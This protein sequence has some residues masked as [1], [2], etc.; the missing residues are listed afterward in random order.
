MAISSTSAL[1][2]YLGQALHPAKAEGADM[3]YFNDSGGDEASREQSPRRGV[4]LAYSHGAGRSSAAGGA[5]RS[6]TDA[7]AHPHTPRSPP[8]A[9]FCA[10]TPMRSTLDDLLAA[11]AGDPCAQPG[12]SPPPSAPGPPPPMQHQ[13]HQ[14]K[15]PPSSSAHAPPRRPQQRLVRGIFREMRLADEA[16]YL[17]DA[18]AAGLAP[19]AVA[20]AMAS[21]YD[22]VNAETRLLSHRAALDAKLRAAA[23]E[24][25]ARSYRRSLMEDLQE[26]RARMFAAC[27][28]V[29][30]GGVGGDGAFFAAAGP[31]PTLSEAVRAGSSAGGASLG[32]DVEWGPRHGGGGGGGGSAWRHRGQ[33]QEQDEMDE[34]PERAAREE[35]SKWDERLIRPATVPS[36][37]QHLRGLLSGEPLAPPAPP[38]PRQ[39][40]AGRGSPQRRPWEPQGGRADQRRQQPQQQQRRPLSAGRDAAARPATSRPATARPATAGSAGAWAGEAVASSLDEL[41]SYRSRFAE[42]QQRQELSQLEALQQRQRRRYDLLQSAA[43]QGSTQGG[44]GHAASRRA[45]PEAHGRAAAAIHL[46][47]GPAAASHD[48]MRPSRAPSRLSPP[49]WDSF[50][51]HPSAAP[52][53]AAAP[54]GPPCGRRCSCAGAQQQRGA[55]ARDQ[56]THHYG[57]GAPDPAA[58]FPL[59]SRL[60]QER[61]LQQQRDH[62]QREQQLR[63]LALAAEAAVLLRP[64]T[65]GGAGAAHHWEGGGGGFGMGIPD[66]GRRFR[67]PPR[68]ASASAAV[69]AGQH[70]SAGG[71]VL[72][73]SKAH[74][75]EGG[76]PYAAMRA[77]LDPQPSAAATAA[78]RVRA[79]AA[80]AAAAA[81]ASGAVPTRAPLNPHYTAPHGTA[82]AA[83]AAAAAATAAAHLAAASRGG[84]GGEVGSI[85]REIVERAQ[86]R[87]ADAAKVNSWPLMREDEVSARIHVH[88]FNS[89]G[90]GESRPPTPKT[91][92]R[93]LLSKRRLASVTRGRPASSSG[94]TSS[95]SDDGGG[96]RGIRGASSLPRGAN[97][98]LAVLQKYAPSPRRRCSS[99]GASTSSDGSGGAGGGCGGAAAGGGVAKLQRLLAAAGAMRRGGGGL[100]ARGA[101]AG[102]DSSDGQEY[103]SP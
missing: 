2:A 32:P 36:P 27:G 26:A 81:L 97:P 69:P 82:A 77:S 73:S 30:D 33:R 6:T 12:P 88:G 44:G 46:S 35:Y 68:P 38:P 84:G 54:W 91:T 103:Y 16:A 41:R 74:A 47:A 59:G 64:S 86:R 5:Q 37:L 92:T 90:R 96:G 55:R 85:T 45:S 93:Q 4:P 66:G 22:G 9:R 1:D 99:G 18:E 40:P 94:T 95:S 50:G 21:P 11:A 75:R 89:G 29:V 23:G 98:L 60:A 14:Q 67:G 10:F 52:E 80:A 79:A 102:T 76:S 56:H 25:E 34:S 83:G 100:Q 17:S 49:R 24:L 61:W 43:A 13:Q 31:G 57:A 7:A 8:P 72:R 39:L 70:N 48:A 87:S 28:G 20:A 51:G 53:A 3:P 63:Q 78:D 101:A 42:R 58:P 19:P 62:L 71:G 15:R 65:A